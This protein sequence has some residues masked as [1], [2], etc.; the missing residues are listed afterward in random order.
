MNER[1]L[2]LMPHYEFFVEPRSFFRMNARRYLDPCFFK[3]LKPAPRNQWVRVL[4]RRDDTSDPGRNK[5]I[6]A[7][8]RSAVMRMR[9]KRNVCC[10]AFSPLA[11]LRECNYLRMS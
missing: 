4:D 7:W 2:F 9:F 10:T 1:T 3:L 5:S 8:R 6:S 11:G